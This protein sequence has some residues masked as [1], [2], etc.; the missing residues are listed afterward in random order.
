MKLDLLRD[1]AA[2]A[3]QELTPE[4]IT[5][6]CYY[7]FDGK[8]Y[9]LEDPALELATDVT[10]ALA[11]SL[12][13]SH[14][15]PSRSRTAWFHLEGL[16][17]TFAL[18]FSSSP[19]ID[20]RIQY[21][22]RLQAVQTNASNAFKVSHNELTGLLSRDAFREKLKTSINEIE[23]EPPK[24][25]ILASEGQPI[26]SL[27]I[28]AFDIDKFKQVNDTYGHIYGDQVLKAFAWRLERAAAAL[29]QDYENKIEIALGHPSGEEFL[30]LV[31][32][33][34]SNEDLAQVAE[35][36]RLTVADEI[37]PT[38]K[39]WKQLSYGINLENLSLPPNVYRSVTTSVGVAKYSRAA[40][41]ESANPLALLDRA[42]IALYKSKSGGRNRVT[43]FDQILQEC[44]KVLEH[45][46]ATGVI[47]IDIGSKVGVLAGQEFKVYPVT[48]C[49]TTPFI[50][51]DGRSKK[52]LGIYPKIELCRVLVFNSQ[53]DMSFAYIT[54]DSRKIVVPA[55]AIL[56]AVPLGSITHLIRTPSRLT[57]G[58]MSHEQHAVFG[59]NELHDYVMQLIK[60]GKRPLAAAIRFRNDNQFL[61]KFGSAALNR[62]LAR[63]FSKLQEQKDRGRRSGI[64]DTTSICIVG[65]AADFSESNLEATLNDAYPKGSELE[66]I[67]GYYLPADLDDFQKE[68]QASE[69]GV[70]DS[71]AI[72]LARFAL[73]DVS[74]LN[75]KRVQQF[76]VKVAERILEQHRSAGAYAKGIADYENLRG[77]GVTS[78]IFE[79]FG[80]LCYSSLKENGKS[81]ECYL[82][83]VD[84]NPEN[85]IFRGNAAQLAVRTEQYDLGLKVMSEIKQDKLESLRKVS[86]RAYWTYAVLL[87]KA[88]ANESSLYSPVLM[89][90]IGEKA[91]LLEH[92]NNSPF[93]PL[94]MAA[95]QSIEQ[96]GK[97]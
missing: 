90:E 95:V 26:R 50:I 3:V 24:G 4:Q 69:V 64:I 7:H 59:G 30:A 97:T 45:E 77:I 66:P 55:G 33:P 21:L 43:H 16:A 15:H 41:G 93:H 29:K 11:R 83:A 20:K 5:V 72:E 88:K 35:K 32:G 85:I 70:Q 31:V 13:D 92:A 18:T 8:W 54:E 76:T 61:E 14:Y 27:S 25:F 38:D 6:A 96:L 89:K 68:G 78:G 19:K 17:T 34:L 87:A 39:E 56:E 60:E 58:E 53:S 9:S 10:S 75:K 79:N 57:G 48:Y 80:G 37:L 47:A 36:F 62:A 82:R 40:K 12:K 71:S 23:S 52:A 46:Q 22:K 28:L 86:P 1:V 74:G 49:G 94:V 42:D 67:C 91:L 65:D 73:T 81:L 63:L 84:I 44:G 2:A 51:D